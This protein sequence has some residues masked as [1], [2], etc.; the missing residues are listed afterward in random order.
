[1][2]DC[3]VVGGGLIGM[4]TARFLAEAGA[5]VTL[6]EQGVLGHEASWAGGGILSPLYPWRY[7]DPVNRLAAYS[8]PLYPDLAQRLFEETGIDPEWTPSGLLVLD[9]EDE[10]AARAWAERYQARIE[11]LDDAALHSDEPALKADFATGM[12]FPEVAQIRNPRLVKSLAASLPPLGINIREQCQVESLDIRDGRIQAVRT[13][14]EHLSAANVLVAGGAWSGGLFPAFR[15]APDIRPVRHYL[16]PRRDGRILAGSTLEE[17]GF[18]KHTTESARQEL[19]AIAFD[20]APGLEQFPIEKQWSGLRPGSPQGIPYI[21]EHP[22]IQGLYLNAGHYRNG[23]VM[24]LASAELAASQI[25]RRPPPLDPRPFGL[26][27]A[28]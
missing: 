23:V 24:G 3:I 25:L 21:G 7:P 13:A 11:Q 9:R 22:E 18:D 16:I 6:L 5:E 19:T 1:M 20:L 17:V 12:L 14:G 10:Q 28:Q 8:Q 15:S 26:D 27:A 4:L 2:T